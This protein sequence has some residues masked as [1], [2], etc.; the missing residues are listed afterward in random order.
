[1]ANATTVPAARSS[2]RKKTS[3]SLQEG[4]M[5]EAL[6]ALRKLR[7]GYV[8]AMS[9]ACSQ[10]DALLVNYANLVKVKSIQATLDK[11]W[12]NFQVNAT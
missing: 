3:S 4:A 5:Q 7:A 11:A 1:M 12:S 9:K 10:I 8:S 2:S 6:H